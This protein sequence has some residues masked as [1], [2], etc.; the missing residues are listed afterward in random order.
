M[1]Q[2][3]FTILMLL[4]LVSTNNSVCADNTDNVPAEKAT[5]VT[6]KE[7]APVAIKAPVVEEEELEEEIVVLPELETTK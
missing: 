7:E 1:K 4:T 2:Y 6:V 5:V 3:I